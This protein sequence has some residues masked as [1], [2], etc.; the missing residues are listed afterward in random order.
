MDHSGPP[1]RTCTLDDFDLTPIPH[2]EIRTERI[3]EYQE[4]SISAPHGIEFGQAFTQ[5]L[6]GSQYPDESQ[7]LDE[8]MAGHGRMLRV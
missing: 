5:A 3:A 2:I 6:E 8:M 1:A 7:N 4:D